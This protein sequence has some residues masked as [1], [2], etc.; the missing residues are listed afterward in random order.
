MSRKLVL[1]TCVFL[2]YA[3][4]NKLYR[5]V[6]AI[7]TYDL[8]ICVNED[9]VKELGRNIPK[10]IQVKDITSKVVLIAINLFSTFVNTTLQ[11]SNCPEPK[12]NFLFDIALQTGSEAIITQE[13]ALLNFAESPVPVRDIVWFKQ[14]FEVPL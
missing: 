1:E 4:H 8:E 5:L 9:L 12:D 7:D 6:N 14:T 13:K 2:T 3:S 10:V 11:F